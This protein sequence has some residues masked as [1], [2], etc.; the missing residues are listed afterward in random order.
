MKHGLDTSQDIRQQ[1]WKELGRGCVDRHH[2]WRTPVLATVGFDGL[3]N[4]RTVVLRKV[5][6]NQ[7]TLCFYTDAR[8]AK[9]SELTKQ[10]KAVLA[11]WSA[12]LNWQ[13]RVKVA[14]SV[15]T[16]G[17]EMQVHWQRVQQSASAGDYMANEAPGTERS[18]GFSTSPTLSGDHHFALLNAQVLQMDWLE[19]GQGGH[20][21]AR[22]SADTWQWLIP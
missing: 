13:L 5:D 15:A 4:V 21:R 2:A 16:E 17:P 11:F 1:I 6:T 18:T 22:L 10:P 20:R 12:R 9:V 7:Q 3:P 19:L 14:I 8:S